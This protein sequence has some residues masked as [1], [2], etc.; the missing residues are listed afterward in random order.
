MSNDGTEQVELSTPEYRGGRKREK[1]T[2]QEISNNVMEQEELPKL[3]LLPT[4]KAPSLPPLPSTLQ[5][6][7]GGNNY[8]GASN[9]NDGD[10]EDWD[11]AGE[12]D[13]SRVTGGH[14]MALTDEY[15][16]RIKGGEVQEDQTMANSRDGEEK[17]NDDTNMSRQEIT[18]D[19]IT[20]KSP[21]SSSPL[22][23]SKKMDHSPKCDQAWDEMFQRLLLY[24]QQHGDCVVPQNNPEDKVLGMWV[25]KQR[26]EHNLKAMEANKQ[27][28]LES[29]G[30]EWI[31]DGQN[32]ELCRPKTSLKWDEMFWRLKEY[33]EEHGNCLVPYHFAEDIVLGRWVRTQRYAYKL[34]KISLDKQERLNSLGFVWNASNT[35]SWDL[36]FLRLECYKGQYGDCRVPHRWAEDTS[37]GKWVNG[38]RVIYKSGKMRTDRKDRL[39]SIGFEWSIIGQNKGTST[40]NTS[41]RWNEMFQ[42]LQHYKQEHGNCLVPHCYAEDITLGRWVR[43]QRSEYKKKKI[44][45]DKQERLDS[46][47]FK[48]SV[49]G[50]T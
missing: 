37:L 48:W 28:L 18:A 35:L 32:K 38:Q 3:T 19:T 1:T 49:N 50:R 8:V 4:I 11:G 9:W 13:F 15:Q 36:M 33:K 31:D 5:D 34:N 30:F 40:S 7:S 16:Q 24:K 26:Q 46:L 44:K 45:P 41:L 2:E 43:T 47:G 23:P 6:Y 12:I 14:H 10:E 27:E 20:S 25:R 39:D 42:R 17:D 21:P 29:I 22:L